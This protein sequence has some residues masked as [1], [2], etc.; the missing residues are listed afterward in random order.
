[1]GQC[2]GYRRRGD[3]I[4]AFA[5]FPSPRLVPAI[6]VTPRVCRHTPATGKTNLGG[7]S[8]CTGWVSAVAVSGILGLRIGIKV[9]FE[10]LTSR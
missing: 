4:A 3:Q 1:M 2:C 5:G 10:H 7:L 6:V 9:L 8:L